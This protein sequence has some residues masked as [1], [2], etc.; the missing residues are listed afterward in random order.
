VCRR[1]VVIAR[2]GIAFTRVVRGW[3]ARAGSRL[4][5]GVLQGLARALK[6]S[7]D[8]APNRADAHW[9]SVERKKTKRE[10]GG[11]AESTQLCSGF[12][13]GSRLK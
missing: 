13:R 2:C 7:K 12:G 6:E 11:D 10:E 9:G 3:M 1:D 4:R 8:S 5:G